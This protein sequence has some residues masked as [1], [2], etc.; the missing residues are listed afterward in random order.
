MA[1]A[2]RVMICTSFLSDSLLPFSPSSALKKRKDGAHSP[3]R[4]SSSL[5]QLQVERE[6]ERER[7]ATSRFSA[8][9]DYYLNHS[10]AAAAAVYA[11]LMVRLLTM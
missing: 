7:K 10:L 8:C 6:R 2:D 5:T 9:M 3:G 1:R 4:P 11:Q